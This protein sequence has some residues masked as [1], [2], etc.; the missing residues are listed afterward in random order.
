MAAPEGPMP[1][2]ASQWLVLVRFFVSP[3][4]IVKYESLLEVW[5]FS[6]KNHSEA[7]CVALGFGYDTFGIWR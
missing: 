1:W 3:G 4:D 6:L 5:A 7:T 2:P